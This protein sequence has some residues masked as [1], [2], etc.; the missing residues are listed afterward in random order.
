M[1]KLWNQFVPALVFAAPVLAF[2]QTQASTVLQDAVFGKQYKVQL[3]LPVTGYAPFTFSIVG[4]ALPSCLHFSTQEGIVSGLPSKACAGTYAFVIDVIDE[5]GNEALAQQTL[6]RFVVH[7]T[8]GKT[9]VATV[10]APMPAAGPQPV[11]ANATPAQAAQGKP[12][13]PAEAEKTAAG[14]PAAGAAPK[15]QEQHPLPATPTPA[16]EQATAATST[17]PAAAAGTKPPQAGAKAPAGAGEAASTIKIDNVTA[18]DL[19]VTA[20]NADA[21]TDY[22]LW[23]WPAPAGEQQPDATATPAAAPAAAKSSSQPIWLDT[24]TAQ[25]GGDLDFKDLAQPPDANAT[26]RI[27]TSTDAAALRKDLTTPETS[28][29][30]TV[31]KQAVVGETPR[32]IVGYE[33]SGANSADSAGRLYMDIYSSHVLRR[34]H[35]SPNSF[36]PLRIFGDVRV[37]SSAQSSS[38][39]V[40]GFVTGLSGTVNG[41]KLNQ[42]ASVAEFLTGMEYSFLHSKG[43]RPSRLSFFGEYGATGMLQSAELNNTYAFPTN[44]SQAYQ[45]LVAAEAKQQSSN[46]TTATTTIPSTCV[47]GGSPKIPGVA[48]N[49]MFIEFIQQQPYFDQ[50]AYIGLKSVSFLNSS[51]AQNGAPAVISFGLGANNAVNRDMRFNTMRFDG[52]VPLTVPTVKGTKPSVPVF[53]LFGYADLAID[54]SNFPNV[55][56]FIPLDAASSVNAG[57]VPQTPSSSNTYVIYTKPHA[58]EY[59]SIGAGVDL[60]NVW[61]TLFPAKKQ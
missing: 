34:S 16:T 47:V 56:N 37:G 38:S 29:P 50:E 5:K 35:T 27:L 32:A 54:H 13:A 40:G 41:L 48:N 7:V 19:V 51:S 52:F 25:P 60:F 10:A 53:Y 14:T 26:V 44:T 18:G 39:T 3:S 30:G 22:E 36:S 31:V 49:C 57:G 9:T 28:Q 61:S 20:S 2:G 45:L 58:Q 8:D 21:G 1:R 4:G 6:Q 24:T 55:N 23:E 11:A 17:T 42:I 15:P 59:Y 12:P 33:Q 46:P 43:T